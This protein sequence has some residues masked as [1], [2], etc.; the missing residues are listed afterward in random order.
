MSGVAVG[1]TLFEIDVRPGEVWRGEFT[2]VTTGYGKPATLDLVVADLAQNPTGAK[3][4]VEPG[5]GSRSAA[6]WIDVPSEVTLSGGERRVVPLSVQCPEGSFGS[7]SAFIVVKLR[8]E[9]TDSRMVT[10]IIPGINV[11]ILARVRSQGA[12]HLDVES[13]EFRDAV[14]RPTLLLTI[15]NA[16]VWKSDVHGD[17]LLYPVSGGFPERVN[18]PFRPDGQP[19]ALYA[20]QLLSLACPLT[21]KLPPGPYD[22]VVRLD[23][24]QGR[25][26]RARFSVDIGSN[27]TVEGS[28]EGRAELGTD[29]WLEEDMFELSLP[30]GGT[31]SVPVRL[32]N[33]G[34]EPIALTAAV[35]DARLE[36]DGAWTFGGALTP[37]PGLHVKI[38]PDSLVVAPKRTA[39]VRASVS[40]DRDATVAST[41]VRGVRLT[42]S[43]TEAGEGRESIYDTGALLV[44]TPATGGRAAPSIAALELIRSDP[45]RN[46]GSAV[47]AV[48][49]RGLATSNIKGT[50]VLRRASGPTIATMAIGRDRWE[51]IT[52]GGRREFR[53]PL[54]IVDEGEFVVAAEIMEESSAEGPLRAEATFT[55]TEA[56]PEGLR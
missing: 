25:E 17:V 5:M 3:M 8:P 20:G 9:S 21:A 40:L 35:E 39:V 1:P 46:P 48:V 51:P 54:P 41:T 7:Y 32:K 30:P 27:E 13:L 4:A 11:E 53:M 2:V 18:I 37:V 45:E 31:R 29:L 38:S 49:N 14:W 6:G 33:L 23:L 42:S 12:L 19:F 10:E 24:G 26:S 16:G 47:L 44:L 56:I 34:D 28:P 52:P 43:P 36:P 22:A 15:R 50:I 55:S